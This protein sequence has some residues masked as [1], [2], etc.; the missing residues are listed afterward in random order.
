[1][2]KNAEN[3]I[4]AQQ[5]S[6]FMSSS[7]HNNNRNKKAYRKKV[8]D[9]PPEAGNTGAVSLGNEEDV[10]LK[11]LQT[12]ELQKLRGRSKGVNAGVG[13]DLN[14]PPS[15]MQYPI[16]NYVK[17]I[18]HH[19][20]RTHLWCTTTEAPQ[21]SLDSNFTTQQDKPEVN[22]HLEKCIYSLAFEQG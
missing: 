22:Q 18:N 10:S 11:L 4:L 15:S 1:M 13:A 12:K 3:S 8:A 19:T 17:E 2:A 6:S 7:Q 20:N 5:R 16:L 21:R 14:L 9:A